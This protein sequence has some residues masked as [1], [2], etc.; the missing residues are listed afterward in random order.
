MA[1][2]SVRSTW[3]ATRV[4]YP[5]LRRLR[6]LRLTRNVFD[7]DV[8]RFHGRL[9]LRL[10]ASSPPADPSGGQGP[11]RRVPGRHHGP[12]RSLKMPSLFRFPPWKTGEDEE[13]VSRGARP[14]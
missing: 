1:R 3:A 5:S 11:L 8:E 9:L 13:L 14:V 2:A 10:I 12:T 6:Q 7:L 4:L